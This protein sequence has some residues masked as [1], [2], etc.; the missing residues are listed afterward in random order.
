MFSSHKYPKSPLFVEHKFIQVRNNPHI[1]SSS[2]NIQN[3]L[4]SYINSISEY[5]ENYREDF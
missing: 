5:L 3:N 1:S 2:S 4:T